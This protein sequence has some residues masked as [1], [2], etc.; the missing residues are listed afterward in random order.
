MF[1]MQVQAASPSLAIFSLD[2]E[3]LHCLLLQKWTVENV[4]SIHGPAQT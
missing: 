4:S 2:N 1:K 3:T